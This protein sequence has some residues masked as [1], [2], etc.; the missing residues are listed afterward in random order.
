MDIES[1]AAAAQ[2]AA[3]TSS[4]LQAAASSEL[5]EYVRAVQDALKRR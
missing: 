1:A 3:A 5:P 2:P 4:L